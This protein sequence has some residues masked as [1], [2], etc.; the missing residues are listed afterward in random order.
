[1]PHATFSSKVIAPEKKVWWLLLDKVEN[2]GKYLP[3]VIRSQILER[4]K[5][6]VLRKTKTS[7]FEVK[8]RI[9]IDE[10]KKEVVFILVDHPRY[11][12]RVINQIT[13]SENKGEVTLTFTLDWKPKGGKEDTEDL[14]PAVRKAVLQTK[15]L[16]EK[17]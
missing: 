12:G 2:P 3:G 7:A 4:S 5:E 17:G 13:P 15:E 16:A 8:E 6:G 14:L 1:M 11:A 9:T 10:H